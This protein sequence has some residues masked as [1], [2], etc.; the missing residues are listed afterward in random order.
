MKKSL[1]LSAFLFLG[2]SAFA[3]VTP[4]SET[5]IKTKG[6]VEKEKSQK[7]DKK[8]AVKKN[9]DK[10]EKETKVESKAEIESGSIYY[11]KEYDVITFEDTVSMKYE[12]KQL[13][14]NKVV[15]DRT[16]R[17]ITAEDGVKLT[18]KKGNNFVAEKMIVDDELKRGTL[19]EVTAEM[20][21]G[22]VIKSEELKILD[23]EKYLLKNSEYSPCK[24]CE[25]GKYLWSVVADRIL[26]DETVGKLLS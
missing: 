11:D 15:Y 6:Q 7:A 2:S 5:N 19:D 25:N 12:G 21:D 26:Y 24:P 1:L 3:Q 9:D 18:G 17:Q 4:S 8:K 23:K 13:E 10:S 14:A 20:V 16:A 22:S